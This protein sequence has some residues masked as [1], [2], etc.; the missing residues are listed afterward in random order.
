MQIQGSLLL[1]MLIILTVFL[2]IVTA[3]SNYLPG[4]I[5]IARWIQFLAPVDMTWAE[6]ITKLA[7]FPWYF[8]LLFISFSL[9]W[10]LGGTRAAFLSLISFGGLWLLDKV[11]KAFIFQPRPSMQVIFVQKLLKGSAFPSTTALIYMATFGFLLILSLTV[12]HTSILSS[13]STAMSLLALSIACVARI[14][15]GAHWPSNILI[16]Y[17]LGATWI[18]FILL[19]FEK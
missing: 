15:T 18:L 7:T 9:S 5:V 2:I 11:L 19:L 13:T 10:M 4:D 12:R 6:W 17:L 14:A 1:C 3:Y 16:S 8:V